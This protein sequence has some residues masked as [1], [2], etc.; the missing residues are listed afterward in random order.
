MK[1]IPP[2]LPQFNKIK[3]PNAPTP[4]RIFDLIPP[5]S[6]EVPAVVWVLETSTDPKL[7]EAAAALTPNLQ[8]PVGLDLRQSM[9]RLSDAFNQCL[10]TGVRSRTTVLEG[11]RDRSISCL[12]A[13]GVLEMVAERVEG[14]SV[15]WSLPHP[16]ISQTDSEL[17]SMVRFFRVS[18]FDSWFHSD[19]PPITHWSLRF[20][21]AQNPPEKHLATVLNFFRPDE[22][23]LR[24][25]SLLGDFLFCVNSFFVPSDAHD[26]SVMD[27]R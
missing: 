20:I 23:S 6:K 5:T 14:S 25:L 18:H 19:T 24:D 9:K 3:P 17:E 27:K 26:L 7:V 21:S 2:H 4:T 10:M 12:K 1:T 8:W 16:Y 11:M 15:L 22:N 13:F